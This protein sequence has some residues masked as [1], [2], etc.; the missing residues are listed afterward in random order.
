[1]P[2]ALVIDDNPNNLS[3]LEQLL[4]IEGVGCV[5]L[6]GTGNLVVK[7]N[8]ISGIDVVFLDLELPH[9]TG[10]DAIQV[11][12]AHPNFVNT[13]VIAYTVHVSE[14]NSVMNRGFDGFI[15]KPVSAEEFP[16]QWRRI[17]NHERVWYIP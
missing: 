5:K 1:M 3:V 7:L 11:I 2:K 12:K 14:L 16:D 13:S 17:L 4:A 9:M 8:A 6:S 15:G 10:Y